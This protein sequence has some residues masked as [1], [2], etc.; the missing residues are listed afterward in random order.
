MGYDFHSS[1]E[2]RARKPY[3]CEE[4]RCTISPGEQYV[5]VAGVWEG[6]FYSGRFC[7][8]CTTMR[9]EAWSAFSWDEDSSPPYGELRS[10]L[11]SE[12]CVGNP[13]AWLDAR[14]A[15]AA[16]QKAE[17]VNAA[18]RDELK[19][20]GVRVPFRFTLEGVAADPEVLAQLGAVE[21]LIWSGQWSAYWRPNCAG[22]AAERDEAGRYTFA[23]AWAS[24]HH[25]GPEKAIAFELAPIT[26]SL[27]G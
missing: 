20:N 10:Y 6:E 15:A 13:E 4:G 23:E 18:W 16:E 9:A 27:G 17:G 7:R 11:R 21:V 22:Y 12:E 25:C 24:T 8:R 1:S 2:R 19:A 26:Q 14:L 3:R 5:R